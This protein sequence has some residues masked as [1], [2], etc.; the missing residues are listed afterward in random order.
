[1]TI[2]KTEL[3]GGLSTRSDSTPMDLRSPDEVSR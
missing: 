2:F 1:M 3:P